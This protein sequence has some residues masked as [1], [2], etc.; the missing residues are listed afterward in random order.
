[1][2]TGKR[3]S[4]MWFLALLL[5]VFA[6]GCGSS[7]HDAAPSSAKAM[8]AYSLNGVTGTIN[9]TAKTISV[10]MPYGTNVT[11]L[12]ATYVSTGT[13]VKVGTVA[14]TSA[15]L[16]SN[17]F[18]NPVTYKVTAADGTTAT[19]T[20]D[21]T[22]A[23]SSAKAITAYSLNGVAGA[24]NETAK[25]ISVTMPYGTSK[26]GLI[27][28]FQTTG[29]GV[30]VGSTLQT[31]ATTS[32]NFTSAVL[33]TVTAADA[34]TAD[35]TVTVTV[36]LN[37]AKAITAYSFA[38]YSGATGTISGGASPYAI[39][40]NVPFGTDVTT[41]AATFSTTGAVVTV[42][43][44]T[45]TTGTT[46]NDFTAPVTYTVTA[47][48]GTK[49]TYVVT[50]T[51]A[52][53]SAKAITAYSI[54]SQTSSTIVVTSITVTMPFST[55]SV[56]ALVATFTASPG[57]IVTVGT[58]TQISG[59][60]PNDFTTPK[61]YTV[62]AANGTS[63]TYTV[64]VKLAAP[65]LANPVAPVL[66]EAGRFV[67]LASQRITTTGVTAIS[68]GDMGIEDQARSYYAGFTPGVNPGQFDELVNGL[69]YAHDDT[70][71]ALIPA[72][73]AST[74][75]F[76][77]QVRTDLGIAYSYLAADPN[78]GVATQVCPIELG[79]LVLKRGVY[80]TAVDV[81][82]TT[83]DLQLDAEGDPNAVW[84]F[85]IDGTLTTGAPGGNISFVG[86]IGQAKNIYWRVAGIT[87]IAGGTTFYGNVF[88]WAQV[89][90]LAGANV[91][92]RL[93]SVN[94]QITLDLRYGYQS[95]V[96]G[97]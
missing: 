3:F 64:T 38:V 29:A 65:L 14:Q 95:S 76:I 68:N 15:A 47:A 2:N 69:S 5:A 48:N 34:T 72:P 56:T 90:V 54:A 49:A 37:S 82:I 78:P 12:V 43:T 39:A 45:Q 86:G 33:Y 30:H 88:N 19:Y 35:Y 84:I 26:T 77:D 31:S 97:R 80:K 89:N 36:A 44:T 62:T 28:T 67:I 74:I 81:G 52:L 40:V 23:S 60:T 11:A 92:G 7:N 85:S 24:I 21:V 27:A 46:T 57:A 73:Y 94:E 61:T 32:N 10:T 71:P 22:V 1:M 6:A 83:G 75:A 63:A 41:L 53:N 87:T 93:Y 91:T 8:T 50:V 79:G 59:S 25:T 66:G 58:T 16:P 18:T 96:T 51:A 17:N 9:E 13:G 55:P 70:D 42:G 4:K 20:V